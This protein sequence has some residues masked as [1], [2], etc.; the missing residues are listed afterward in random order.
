M[1]RIVIVMMVLILVFAF[2]SCEVTEIDTNTTVAEKEE[3]TTGTNEQTTGQKEE[4]STET[5]EETT[6]RNQANNEIT[7]AE[8]T[9]IDN[10]EIS[11]TITKIDPDD[12]WGYALDVRLENKSS[13]KTY[14]FALYG[15]TVNGVECE[16]LLAEEVAPGKKANSSIII[17]G[18]TL[19]EN[20]ITLFTDIALDF[21]VYNSEDWLDE[22]L[23]FETVHIYPYGKEKAEK[24]V[25]ESQA[26]DNV[27]V[28]NENVTVIVTGYEH[29]IIWGYTVNM[30]VI[31][32]TDKE[33]ML[34]A[35]EVSVNGYMIDP[36]FCNLCRCR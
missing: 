3:I 6:E 17:Y 8:Q 11:I 22:E 10:D 33:V 28:D 5:K 14:M 15:V 29:D 26:T 1:K 34:S 25:R 12:F 35:D 19:E 20:G 32:H 7:F 2:V 13:E 31:N 9:V 24:Y 36:F 30:F 16:A 18:D 27:I 21:H 4:T 23:S